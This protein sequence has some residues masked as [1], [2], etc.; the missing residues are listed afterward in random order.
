LPPAQE[1]WPGCA[2]QAQTARFDLKLSPVPRSPPSGNRLERVQRGVVPPDTD[3]NDDVYAWLLSQANRLREYRP[4]KLDWSGLAE[5]LEDIV[6]LQGA[7]VVSLLSIV[8]AHLLEWHYSKIRRSE[9]SWQKNLVAARTEL[10]LILDESRILR[11]E[12]P[13]FLVKAYAPALRLAGTDIWHRY[14]VGK[15]RLGATFPSGLPVA[16]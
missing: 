15:M 9:R 3:R 8:Q 12:L 5:E 1:P 16:F 4:E 10:N 11:N 6:A 13:S 2:L 7:K 14:E